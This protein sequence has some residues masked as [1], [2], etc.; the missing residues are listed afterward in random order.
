MACS[1]LTI[2]SRVVM[3]LVAWGAAAGGAAGQIVLTDVTSRSGI[4]FRHT[5][6]S[7]GQ[8]YIVE[9][10]SAGLAL[11]DYD[12]DGQIDIYLL[13][14]A[15]LKGAKAET[16]PRNAL[17]RNLGKWRFADVS[18]RSGLDD[19]GYG[20]GVAVGDYDNDGDG[21]VY[22]NNHGPNVLYRNNGDGTFS[23]V[24]K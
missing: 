8:R 18:K 20:L 7:S 21:D 1:R 17:Y 16:A 24:T 4:A 2:F 9:T 10:V 15:P 22:L 12:N 3:S 6:G 23:D 5:D 11:F 19:A 14:G 13:N